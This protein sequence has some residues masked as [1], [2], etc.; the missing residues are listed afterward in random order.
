[1]VVWIV[2]ISSRILSNRSSIKGVFY[3]M[4]EGGRGTGAGVV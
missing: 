4:Y 2:L 3:G 1:M